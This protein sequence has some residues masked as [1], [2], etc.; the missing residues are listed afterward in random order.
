MLMQDQGNVG[1]L[2]QQM[3]EMV[4][5]GIPSHWMPYVAVE[6][7]AATAAKAKEIG[8]TVIKDAFDVFDIGS[9]AVLK[10]PT[11]AA[12]SVWQAK[13]HTGSDFVDRRPG[14]VCWNELATT[15]KQEAGAF[16][17]ELFGWESVPFEQSPVPYTMFRIGETHAGGVLE[18][19]EE[20]GGI[21]PH[22]MVYFAVADCDGSADRAKELG[23]EV[24]V[25]PTDI[26]PVGRF[27]VIQ[28]PQGA[29]FSVIKLSPTDSR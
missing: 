29:V 14:T 4:A 28:D 18:M 26:P 9:M 20:W 12:F 11:G 16:Y 5:A 13:Q 10:D 1:A 17:A 7:A 2:Y 3:P 22:W 6:D 21:P 23:G 25:P 27:A 15:D 24:K 8:G 19:T